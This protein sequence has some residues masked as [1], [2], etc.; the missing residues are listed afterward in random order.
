MSS[1]GSVA[2]AIADDH[3][4][5]IARGLVCRLGHRAV[6]K[7]R[8]DVRRHGLQGITEWLREADCL[9]H[10]GP[11]F[12]KERR[13]RVRLVVLLITDAAGDDEAAMFEPRQ[14]ALRGSRAG[15]GN[16]ESTRMHRNCGQ[17]DRKA[18]GAR[19]AAFW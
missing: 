16:R 2:E 8:A 1:I 9:Q 18:P 15:A 10:D 6:H 5:D 17:A 13:L 14:F 7:R 19:V 3:Q 11:E 12:A 4:V